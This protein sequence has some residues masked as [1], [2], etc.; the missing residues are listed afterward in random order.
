MKRSLFAFIISSILLVSFAA[1][2]DD[3]NR[4]A[5]GLP[6]KIGISPAGSPM[7]VSGKVTLEGSEQLRRQPVIRVTVLVGG[8]PFATTNAQKL[9][10]YY[11]R[12]IP[13][14]SLTL[15]VEVDGT[16]VSRQVLVASG[17]GNLTIDVSVPWI[18][19]RSAVKP[20]VI[21]VRDAYIRSESAE[22]NFR[23]ALEA[24]RSGNAAEAVK[25]FDI[26]LNS[27]K[28]DYEAWTELGNIYFK[29]NLAS[30]AEAAYYKAIELKR[31]Y[32]TALINL[33]KLYFSLKRFDEAVLVLSNAAK[34]NPESADAHH[35]L[36]ESY[37]QVKKGSLA[38]QEFTSAL[39][40]APEE[41]AE[42]HLRLA[43]LYDAAN[44]KKK[45]VEEYKLF[46]RKRPDYADKEQLTTY[47]KN[48]EN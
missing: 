5:T 38:V 14:Q 29:R 11:L 1:G 47:I 4:E 22:A 35:F 16:E 3:E 39:K 17:M 8:I 23:K 26:I 6:R 34:V 30:N 13:R 10:Y 2:Q 24:V 27:D 33:G 32:Y 20:G 43:A 42:L 28:N 40:V 21:N 18:I 31:D 15:L 19:L 7:I 48:N 46:L 12:D 9:G 45:A 37:L 25:L 44:M 36:G 41:K